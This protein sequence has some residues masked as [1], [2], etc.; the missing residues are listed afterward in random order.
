MYKL[1]IEKGAEKDIKDIRKSSAGESMRI[2]SH[3]LSLKD[4][5]RPPGVRKIVGSKNDWRLRIGK[6]RVIYEIQAEE[7][8]VYL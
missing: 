1:Q 6:Y 2:I 5:P 7:V 8:L 4:T 3:I